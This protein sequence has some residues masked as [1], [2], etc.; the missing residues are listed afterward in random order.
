V[1]ITAPTQRRSGRWSHREVFA[2]LPVRLSDPP[3]FKR[4][5][6]WAWL[7]RVLRVQLGFDWPAYIELPK[8]RD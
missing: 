2:W 5:G 4:N 7:R 8:E 1:T 6:R 3:Y